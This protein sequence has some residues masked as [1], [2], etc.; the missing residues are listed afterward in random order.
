MSSS[1]WLEKENWSFSGVFKRSSLASFPQNGILTKKWQFSQHVPYFAALSSLWKGKQIP[2]HCGGG[3]RWREAV[4][5]NSPQLCTKKKPRSLMKKR[6]ITY[7][8]KKK[9]T[10]KDENSTACSEQH[11]L[12][13]ISTVQKCTE[14]T[15]KI[16]WS[17]KKNPICDS[18]MS[19]TRICFSWDGKSD[20]IKGE[21]L[22]GK[23]SRL[24]CHTWGSRGWRGSSQQKQWPYLK[25]RSVSTRVI[26]HL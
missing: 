22:L 11:N 17:L 25:H 20:W 23:G 16:N 12:K 10:E 7:F 9:M 24:L 3:E 13:R 8:L 18:N 14:K 15:T 19:Q 5:P 26:T 21:V 2:Y 4:K 6:K 1:W